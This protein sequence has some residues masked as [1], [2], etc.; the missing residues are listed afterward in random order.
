M[1]KKVKPKKTYGSEV[2]YVDNSV[3]NMQASKICPEKDVIY[4]SFSRH[5]GHS[6]TGHSDTIRNTSTGPA[7]LS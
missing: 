4:L 6:D 1:S 5:T 3:C 7:V 2:F